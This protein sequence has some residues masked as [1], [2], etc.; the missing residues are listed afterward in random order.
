VQAQV[1]PRSQL[2]A[3]DTV[4]GP[5]LI[6]EDETTIVVPSSR[7]AIARPD[8]TIDITEAHP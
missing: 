3:G 6:T 7:V 1:V 5:A 4:K 2:A 8:G